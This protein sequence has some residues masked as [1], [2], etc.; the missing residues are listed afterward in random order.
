MRYRTV[1][2]LETGSR[3][4]LPG[5]GGEGMESWGQGVSLG[6]RKEISGRM[7]GWSQHRVMY[8][9]PLNT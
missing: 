3:K 1:I 9:K 8:L 6:R 5:A 7:V 2:L 4:G